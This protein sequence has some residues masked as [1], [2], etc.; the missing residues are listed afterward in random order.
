MLCRQDHAEE[1]KGLSGVPDRGFD[2]IRLH[3]YITK[4]EKDVGEPITQEHLLKY[5]GWKMCVHNDKERLARAEHEAMWPTAGESSG[6]Q[7]QPGR[8][9]RMER[10]VI[11]KVE[12]DEDL[13]PRIR[14]NE[15]RMGQI[16][17]AIDALDDPFEQEVLRLIYIDGAWDEELQQYT[18]EQAT[19]SEVARKMRGKDDEASAAWV[20]RLHQRALQ[21]IGRLLFEG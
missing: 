18:Y 3:N 6:S 13:L 9:D 1:K 4:R 10:A 2:I 15:H 17:R 12:L 19:Q 20:K 14:G 11:R 8:G 21:S 7:H 5:L 16:T